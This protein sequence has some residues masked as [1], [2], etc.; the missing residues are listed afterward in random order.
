M[1]HYG[2][3]FWG[4]EGIEREKEEDITWGASL[5]CF[6][7][8]FS[9]KR[10]KVRFEKCFTKRYSERE[11]YEDRDIVSGRTV[12]FCFHDY[13]YFFF[14]LFF[15]LLPKVLQVY[16]WV[17]LACITGK[18]KSR[19]IFKIVCKSWKIKVVTI[20]NSQWW[21]IFCWFYSSDNTHAKLYIFFFAF[22]VHEKI[23]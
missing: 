7:Y 5:T 13:Y 21:A 19:A 22:D 9:L 11:R 6:F 2:V 15:F 1:A 20:C 14:L 8:S 12:V 18:V 4:M 23:K 16:K 10:E 3:F 17:S